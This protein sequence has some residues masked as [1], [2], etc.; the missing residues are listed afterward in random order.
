LSRSLSD[1]RSEVLSVVPPNSNTVIDGRLLTVT[2]PEEHSDWSDF[3]CLGALSLA[4]ALESDA[5]V[6]AT[7]VDGTIIDIEDIYRYIDENAARILAV[8]VGVLTANYEAGMMI[9]RHA[10][11]V[12]HRIWTVVGNDHFSALPAECMARSECIDF[13]FVGN[14]VV[15][16]FT[17]LIGDLRA[18]RQVEPDSYPGLVTRG[19]SGVHVAA[20]APED[21]FSGYDYRVV[22]R[23]FDHTPR[24]TSQFQSRIAP[25][26]K[27]LLGKEVTAGVP[28]DIGRGCIKFAKNDACTFC[29]IQYGGMWRNSLTAETAWRAIEAACTAGYDYLYVTADE[30][31]LTFAGLL[32]GMNRSKP[33][34]WEALTDN[35][36]P[37][38]VGYARADGIADPRRTSSLVELGVRQVMIGMD[39][40]AP[41]SLAA[42]NKPVRGR[43]E[44]AMR[45]AEELY[46]A[47]FRA[48]G[49]ARDAGMLV[50]AG[51]VVGHLGMTSNLLDENLERIKALIDQGKDVISAVD[52]EVLSPQ[53][54]ALDFTYLTT[55]DVA[56]AASARLG[57][58]LADRSELERVAANWRG[59]DVVVP[60]LAMRD[61]A[62][63]F[64]PE[65]SFDELAAARAA[66]R[67]HAKRSG[68]VVGE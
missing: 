57:L 36:R 28:I 3:L 30:L 2:R 22:D 41:V 14:E 17:S 63:A 35:D 4:C 38:I 8:C 33:P 12:D 25:R 58:Q 11:A 26:M 6:S 60:E 66:I 1:H 24:Y 29:S 20:H 21:L 56:V 53:P 42:M 43:Q 40:G 51:F 19:P 9:L 48:L 47:N 55:P 27:E 68:A 46:E 50:R 52:V 5:D 62:S 49:V 61:F 64:M 32:A 44:D 37:M 7:Y 15:G 10:K 31:P 13:G 23:G 16:P 39:A 18:G 59:T 65:V 67:S 34:W 45:Q 54:G